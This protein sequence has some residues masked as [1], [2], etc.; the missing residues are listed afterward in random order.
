MNR[1][2]LI[3]CL[4]AAASPGADVWAVDVNPDAVEATQ[5][6]VERH[7]LPVHVALPDD[8]PADLVVDE[9]WSNPP[10]RV[11]KAALHEA[12]LRWLPHLAPDGV[13][14][15]VVGRNLGADTLQRWLDEQGW[16]TERVGSEKGFRLLETRRP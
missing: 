1:L 8:V 13:A 14:R 7:R 3:A 2:R 5:R 16:P 15:M 12:L 6:N 10:V 11:G 4:L 9:I